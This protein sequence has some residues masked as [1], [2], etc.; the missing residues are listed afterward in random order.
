MYAMSSKSNLTFVVGLF[1]VG[2]FVGLFVVGLFVVG[3]FVVGLFVV[4]L[5]VGLFVGLLVVGLVVGLT[6]GLLVKALGIHPYSFNCNPT[7]SVH[8]VPPLPST[9]VNTFSGH[10]TLATCPS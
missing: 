2:L 6:V 7:P 4:G 9:F 8:E 3:L 5:F 1:V 10:R